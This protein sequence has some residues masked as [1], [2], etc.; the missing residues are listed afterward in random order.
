MSGHTLRDIRSKSKKNKRSSKGSKSKKDKGRVEET[1]DIEAE[2]E[3][4]PLDSE[5]LQGS[6]SGNSTLIHTNTE[7]VRNILGEKEII[8]ITEDNTRVKNFSND[9]NNKNSFIYNYLERLPPTEKYKRRVKCLVKT[10][11]GYCGHIMGSDGSTGNFIYHLAKH[12]ITRE[13]DLSQSDESGEKTQNYSVKKDRLDRKFV[14]IIIKD[15]QPLSIRSDEG[16]REFVKDLDPFYELPSD[17]KIKELLANSYNYCKKEIVHLFD[18]GTSCSLTLDLWTSRSR[19]GYLGVTSSFVNEQFELCEATLAIEYLK[20]PHTSENIVKRLNQII[21]RWNLIDKVFTITT[22]NGSNM[23]KL[24]KL[25]KNSKNI[26]RFPCAA[27]T[28]QLV[29]GKGLIPAERLVARAKR[30]INF[31]T[32]PKQTERLIEIQKSMRRNQEE[33]KFK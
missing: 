12:R 31:F 15:E 16:F 13:A 21:E 25:L 32:T 11:T 22:D 8:D 20:Y 26:T 14:G 27:H 2:I 23:V 7:R 10:S 9:I 4:T 19:S 29:I 6:T 33:V 5:V 24:G 1:R 17:K 28:L 30:L 3:R 18:Q